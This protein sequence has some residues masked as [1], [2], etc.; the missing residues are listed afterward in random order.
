MVV[1][2]AGRRLETPRL[3]WLE[4]DKRIRAPGFARITSPTEDVRGYNLDAA[5][6]LSTY[7]LTRI[8]A[9]VEVDE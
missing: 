6:D 3:T 8:V 5:E 2:T 7:R 1:T 9:D 4:A